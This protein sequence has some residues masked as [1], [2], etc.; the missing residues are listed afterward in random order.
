M[1]GGMTIP[2]TLTAK[3]QN[4]KRLGVILVMGIYSAGFAATVL[5][6]VESCQRSSFQG[7]THLPVSIDLLSVI[8]LPFVYL[9]VEFVLVVVTPFAKVRGLSFQ[10]PL[11]PLS[12]VSLF[13]FLLLFEAGEFFSSSS[14]E[15]WLSCSFAF[16]IAFGVSAMPQTIVLDIK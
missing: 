8:L 13:R 10:V 2:M 6:N 15:R 4:I 1:L 14:G 7:S 12:M 11:N 9:L 3:P 5:A 16:L